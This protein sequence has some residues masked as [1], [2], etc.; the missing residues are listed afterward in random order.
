MQ[1]ISTIYIYNLWHHVFYLLKFKYAYNNDDSLSIVLLL[2]VHLENLK[3]RNRTYVFPYQSIPYL[4]GAPASC[5][6]RIIYS[7]CHRHGS[8]I[9]AWYTGHSTVH[10]RKAHFVRCYVRPVQIEIRRLFWSSHCFSQNKNNTSI[11]PFKTSLNIP[12]GQSEAANQRWTDNT[13]ANKKRINGQAMTY[14]EN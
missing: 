9:C 14:K 7:T 11:N 4:T 12:K 8:C 6:V 3:V 10:Q 13:M 5:H 1:Y 2:L